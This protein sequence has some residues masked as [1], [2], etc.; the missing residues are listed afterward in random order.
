MIALS[1]FVSPSPGVMGVYFV[2][3]ACSASAAPAP[4]GLRGRRGREGGKGKE[5]PPLPGP[6][7][8][9]HRLERSSLPRTSPASQRKPRP[10]AQVEESSALPRLSPFSSL[11]TH[12]THGRAATG[13]RAAQGADRLHQAAGVGEL[14]TWGDTEYL[15]TLGPGPGRARAGELG[16]GGRGLWAQ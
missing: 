4:P 6:R 1:A 13:L 3:C 10:A 12:R 15:D 7:T 11:H 16:C 5:E 8:K 2:D 9:D 14:A